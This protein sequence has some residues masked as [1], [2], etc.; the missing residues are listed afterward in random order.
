[1][2]LV[3][4]GIIGGAVGRLFPANPLLA[5]FVGLISHFVFDAI[6]HWHYPMGAI[7]PKANFSK[8]V[9]TVMKRLILDAFII[10][11][12]FFMGVWLAMLIFDKNDYSNYSVFAG[13]V[14]GLFP[15]A[16]MLLS[17][18]WR[19]KIVMLFQKFHQFIHTNIYLDE[20]HVF[21][22]LS[23]LAIIAA[24]VFISKLILK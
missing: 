10:A 6:P 17:W 12:D 21:G 5:F 16:I 7:D 23:Q 15:D 3:T 1:M 11:L 18:I 8:T 9:F 24:V 13:A 14:G 20:R 19:T 2:I 4:H 22:P